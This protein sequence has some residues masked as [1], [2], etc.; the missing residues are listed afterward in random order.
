MLKVGGGVTKATSDLSGSRTVDQ[1]LDVT[2]RQ[3]SE[4]RKELSSHHTAIH[5]VLSLLAVQNLGSPHLRFSLWPMPL[6]DIDSDAPDPAR[7]YSELLRHRSSGIEGVQDFF[8]IALVPD[9]VEQVCI[10]ADVAEVLL[11]SPAV[12]EF[13]YQPAYLDPGTAAQQIQ[14]YLTHRFP[15]GTPT[16]E[17][18]NETVNLPEEGNDVGHAIWSRNVRPVD[19]ETASGPTGGI[20]TYI[21]EYVGEDGA[22]KWGELAY[23]M[24]ETVNLELQRDAHAAMLALAPAERAALRWQSGD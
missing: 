16:S 20:V 13:H 4:E 10:D 18:A 12:E 22:Y 15:P 23:K 11:V 7:W 8:A 21:Y 9:D 19:V 17:L 1:T 14:A 5:N 3:A 6:R 2:N 24:A